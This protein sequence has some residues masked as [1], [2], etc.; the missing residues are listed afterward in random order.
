VVPPVPLALPPVPLAL[1]PVPLALPPVPLALPP[2]PLELPPE[3]T[4]PPVPKIGAEGG[5]EQPTTDASPATSPAS[6]TWK[7]SEDRI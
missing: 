4:L 2:V 3:P 6:T 5:D 7:V 1:P